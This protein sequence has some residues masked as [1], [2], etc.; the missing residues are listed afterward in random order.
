MDTSCLWDDLYNEM[1]YHDSSVSWNTLLTGSY[2]HLGETFSPS[3]WDEETIGVMETKSRQFKKQ[4]I[5][6]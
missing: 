5:Q 6:L 3:V 1:F 4:F 2:G